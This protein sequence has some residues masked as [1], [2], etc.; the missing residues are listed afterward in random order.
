MHTIYYTFWELRSCCAVTRVTRFHRAAAMPLDAE[1][2]EI[3]ERLAS[4][5]AQ[6]PPLV[7]AVSMPSPIRLSLSC[8]F[9]HA[10]AVNRAQKHISFGEVGPKNIEQVRKLNL[11]VF[12]VR[13]NEKFY[14]DLAN[15]PN[16]SFTHLAFFSDVLCGA[17]CCRI[18]KPEG[19]TKFNIYIMT[20]GVLA[21]YRRLG[22]GKLTH[23]SALPW[24]LM[25]TPNHSMMLACLCIP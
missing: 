14:T 23:A 12:P 15:N 20:I 3:K 9:F 4:L 17:I 22:I 5:R 7:H 24:P 11:A 19:A 16:Q 10:C 13:Y 18:E 6:K 2:Q 1:E 25:P 8:A 21:P